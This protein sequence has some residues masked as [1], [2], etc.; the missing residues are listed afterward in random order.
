[1]GITSKEKKKQQVHRHFRREIHWRVVFEPTA[2]EVSEQVVWQDTISKAEIKV[3]LGCSLLYS[4]W[5]K[6]GVIFSK[7]RS[8]KCYRIPYFS[9]KKSNHSSAILHHQTS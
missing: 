9:C 4:S 3:C 2:V 6:G 8:S 5:R 7:L 1:M